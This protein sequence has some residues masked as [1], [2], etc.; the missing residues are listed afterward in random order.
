MIL[1]IAGA[2]RHWNEEAR[3]QDK[4]RLYYML[5]LPILPTVCMCMIRRKLIKLI[6]MK[7]LLEMDEISISPGWLCG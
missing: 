5:P 2:A 6:I 7:L 4:F 3:S 1:P